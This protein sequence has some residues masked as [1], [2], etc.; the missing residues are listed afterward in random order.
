MDKPL[1]I[2]LA[3]NSKM[4]AKEHA[5]MDIHETDVTFAAR[6]NFLLA[7]RL[8]VPDNA[9]YGLLISSATAVSSHFYLPFALHAAKRG[10][11]AL[12][13]DCR[14]VGRSRPEHLAGFAADMADWGKLD[15]PSALDCLAEAIPDKP[16]FSIGHSVGGHF[17]GFMDNF[18]RFSAHA[19]VSVGSGYW[20]VHKLSDWFM[21]MLFWHV[22]GPVSIRKYGYLK[23]SRSWRGTDLPA[24]VFAQW[25]RWCLTSEYLL[26]DL[27]AG[28]LGECWF[29]KVKAP[30]GWFSFPD[31]PVATPK[32]IART[33]KWY[34]GADHSVFFTNPAEV[35]AGKIG[36]MGAFTGVARGFWDK[37]LDWLVAQL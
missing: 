12:V 20:G 6:D 28:L 5:V 1:D 25:K 11:A 33:K 27:C 35:G 21:E 31:D 10:F 37:P 2:P 26:P 29:D 7:G 17:P 3:S 23:R 8:I 24:G 13:Y 30:I 16:L 19:F 22:I 15:A 34:S 9:R 18:D 4:P 36:H 32:S 14:G